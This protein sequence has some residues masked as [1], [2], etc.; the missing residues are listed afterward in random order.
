MNV[1]AVPI[2][3][4]KTSAGTKLPAIEPIVESA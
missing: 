1:A 2:S 3:G 4:I